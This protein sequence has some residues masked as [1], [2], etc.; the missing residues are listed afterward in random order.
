MLLRSSTDCQKIEL[1]MMG[2]MGYT[3]V[4]PSTHDGTVH[5]HV[6]VVTEHHSQTPGTTDIY[7]EWV[8]AITI[9]L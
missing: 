5:D 6:S 2:K 8:G 1:L 9:T 3:T 4:F 7:T